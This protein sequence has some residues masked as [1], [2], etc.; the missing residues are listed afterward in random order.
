MDNQKTVLFL[1]SFGTSILRAK[2]ISYDKIQADIA[3]KTGLPVWQVF[4]DDSTANAMNG[5]GDTHTY[6]V[7][8]ALE[9]AIIHGFTRVV[10]V[11]VFFA[12]GE[13]YKQLKTRLNYYRDRIDIEMTEAVVHDA[14]SAEETAAALL[15]ALEPSPENEY[16][17]VGHGTSEK[18]S[19]NYENLDKAIR[20]KGYENVRVLRLKDRDCTGQA[21]AWLKSREADMRDAHVVIV[22]LVVAWGDYMAGELYNSD[23]SLMWQLR[24][25]GFRTVFTGNGLGQYEE[26]RNIYLKRLQK[27]DLGD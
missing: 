17:F 3:L 9:T 27:I 8:D 20:G 11:P 19:N 5:F 1:A 24:K 6:R 7:E 25:A 14:E 12:Q 10:V 16:L 2:S 13:L 23:D 26:F 15:E 22:P 4:T 18:F 21:I